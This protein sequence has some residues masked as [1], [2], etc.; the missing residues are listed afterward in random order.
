MS[1]S[2][3]GSESILRSEW[4]HFKALESDARFMIANNY[5]TFS[6]KA[7]TTGGFLDHNTYIRLEV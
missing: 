6:E 4:E 7:S 2:Q 1:S 3:V 5:T